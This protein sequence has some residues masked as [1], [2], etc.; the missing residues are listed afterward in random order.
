[1]KNK[2]F[3]LLVL[4]WPFSVVYGIVVYVRNWLF[5][6]GILPSEEFDLPV[7]SVGNI[8]VGG[9]GKTPFTEYLIRLLKSDQPM[10]VLSRGY[11]RKTSGFKVLSMKD[12]PSDVGDEPYQMKHK[13]PDVT[14]AVDANRRRGIRN[15]MKLEKGKPELIVLDDAF[16]HRY[17]TPSI[18][19]LLIDYNR[20]ILE[21][22]LLPMGQM[23]EHCC[24]MRRADII[25]VTKCPDSVTP[26]DMR[27]MRKNLNPYPYQSLWFTRLSYGEMAPLFPHNQ[28]KKHAH[29][30]ISD[31]KECS[32]LALT[33]IASPA[34]FITYLEQNCAKVE[35]CEFRDHHSYTKSDM[36]RIVKA[37]DQ[38]E[39]TRKYIITTEKD[40]VRLMSCDIF[41]EALKRKIYYIPLSISFVREEATQFEEHLRKLI[42]RKK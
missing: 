35:G 27:F 17:V 26:M 24:S 30:T 25:V 23:R 14:V 29:L 19:I 39:G 3:I 1:M 5:D 8:T 21:D 34:P 12:T 18:S 2:P 22:H 16:Q 36:D 10:G 33:G 38:L 32:V 6:R 15:M 7:I 40:A 37:F 20:N 42:R 9:T 13:F 4:L 41:P 28:K 11:K 31:M